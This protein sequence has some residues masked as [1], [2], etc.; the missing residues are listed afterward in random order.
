MT[1]AHTS[2]H[3]RGAI[4]GI[5]AASIWGG[6]YVVSDELL[7]V[8]PA[9]VLL[10][11][12]LFIGAIT[13]LVL[14]RLTSA[15]LPASR[16]DLFKLLGVGIVGFGIS[17]G[18]QFVG[19]QLS[20]AINGAVLTSAS[21][22]FILI[23]AAL[24]LREPL[25]LRRIAAVGLASVGVLVVLDL[26]QFQLTGGN[27]GSDLLVGNLTLVFAALTWGAYSVLVRQAS[28][29]YPTLTVT[30]FALVG[31]LGF[32]L[33]LGL[34]ELR[35]TSLPLLTFNHLLGIL[36]LGVVSTAG[37]MWLWNRAFALVEASTASLFFFAQPLVGAILSNLLLSQAI[38]PQLVIGGS[39]IALG[40]LIALTE[41]G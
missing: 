35:D 6:M 1:N 15:P 23:F 27:G 37:A 7:K 36:Y 38:T 3:L 8:Y 4:Y 29:K 20:T 28:S 24:L 11:I 21:P 17:V 40:V 25:T 18:A 16:A 14:G 34:F 19:T 39:L 13:L 10:G 12:R 9:F 30:T 5:G 32:C 26:S 22:A 2:A 41:P 33:P 31:G